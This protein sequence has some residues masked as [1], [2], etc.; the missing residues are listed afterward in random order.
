MCVHAVLQDFGQL[1]QDLVE[2]SELGNSRELRRVL[3]EGGAGNPWERC[4]CKME[5]SSPPRRPILKDVVEVAELPSNGAVYRFVAQEAVDHYLGD[6]TRLAVT[7]KFGQCLLVKLMDAD[8]GHVYPEIFKG[9]FA[10]VVS[11]RGGGCGLE[12]FDRFLC[13]GELSTECLHVIW[14]AVGLAAQV[15]D[16]RPQRC[17]RHRVCR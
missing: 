6:Q 10:R 8:V 5:L 7:D 3:E 16:D 2:R 14:V 15:I 9:V 4:A 13:L 1:G 17:V 12:F 11:L